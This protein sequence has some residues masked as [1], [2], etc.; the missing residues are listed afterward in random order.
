VH[1]FTQNNLAIW[2]GTCFAAPKITGML[3]AQYAVTNSL[4][5]AWQNLVSGHTQNTNM[6]VVFQV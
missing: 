4:N 6:G 1:D 3:A 5:Q 2:S